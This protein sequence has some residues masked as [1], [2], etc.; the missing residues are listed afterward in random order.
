MLACCTIFIC[1]LAFLNP[2]PGPICTITNNS[3]THKV[4]VNNS[5]HKATVMSNPQ[6][7]M[8]MDWD[9]SPS[10]SWSI[11]TRYPVCVYTC[12]PRRPWMFL[13]ALWRSLQYLLKIIH[14][15]M[16]FKITQILNKMQKM[17]THKTVAIQ[18]PLN[19]IYWYYVRILLAGHQ[20][21]NTSWHNPSSLSTTA[22]L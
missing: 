20:S 5:S 13:P 11:P 17:Y 14:N 2:L 7:H 3:I 18:H 4:T 22:E 6:H 9:K 12:S 8:Y 19:N 10:A 21:T 15:N 16:I 1:I